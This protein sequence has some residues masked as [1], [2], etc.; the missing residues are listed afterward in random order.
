MTPASHHYKRFSK[1]FCT[2]KVKANKTMKMQEI[3]NHSG[4]KGKKAKSN[5]DSA[6]HNQTLKQQRQLND[7]DHQIPINTN[8]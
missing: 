7:R 6:T 3:L 5:T 2:M 4:R 1:E 8:T